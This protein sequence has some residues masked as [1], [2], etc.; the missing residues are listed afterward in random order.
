M[1][2]KLLA[3]LVASFVA[4]AGMAL[5]E[6]GH[7]YVGVKKCSMCHKSEGKGNQYGQWLSTAHAK[8]YG[9]LASPE[10]KESAKKVGL[11]G[12]PQQAPQCLKCHVTG[13]GA[14]SSLFGEGYAKEDGVQCESC[15][16]A[17]ADYAPL[18]VMKDKDKAVA[19]GLVIPTKEVCVKCHNSESPNYKEFNYDEFH[20]KIAHPMPKKSE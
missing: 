4:M 18:S 6:E 16:G 19:A 7:K 20:K 1:R 11:A 5:A 10:A 2:K 14:D 9:T 13:Y 17:G 12:D 8:A 15:H 3:V